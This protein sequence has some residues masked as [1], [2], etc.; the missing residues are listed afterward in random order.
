[1]TSAETAAK[2]DKLIHLER[3]IQTAET[4]LVALREKYRDTHPDV[5]SAQAQ[6]AGLRQARDALLK[7]E[8]KKRRS[9]QKKE[10]SVTNT[11]ADGG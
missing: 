4:N 7:E 8:E 11:E 1:M 2:N 10:P 9:P 3:Q 6:L 5:R